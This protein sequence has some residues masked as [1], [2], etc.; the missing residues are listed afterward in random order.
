MSVQ[1]ESKSIITTQPNQ[2][3]GCTEETK[4]ILLDLREE[5]D[6]GKFHIR[7]AI[8]FPAPNISRD[9]TFSQLLRFKN[10]PDKIIVVYMSDERLGTHYAKILFEKGFDNISLLTGGIEK[11]MEAGTECYSLVEGVSVPPQ[12]KPAKIPRPGSA[13]SSKR[14]MMGMTSAS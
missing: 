12:P 10:N 2:L 6:Y 3:T 13:A 4:F 11:F 7:E 5:E 9:K 14:S 1:S 8:N